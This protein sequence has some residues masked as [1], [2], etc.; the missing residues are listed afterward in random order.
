VSDSRADLGTLE[1]EEAKLVAERVVAEGALRAEQEEARRRRETLRQIF[2][3]EP[4]ELRVSGGHARVRV[5]EAG[6]DDERDGEREESFKARKGR[7]PLPV[8]RKCRIK[9]LRSEELGGPYVSITSRK[10]SNVRAVAAGTVA[11]ADELAPY[12]K[13]VVL[14]HGDGYFTVYGGLSRIG[15]GAGAAL[16]DGAVVGAV[17]AEAPMVFQI[18]AGARTLT[19]ATW[20]R[21]RKIEP[22]AEG[23]AP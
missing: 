22:A 18:R 11:F 3:A 12:G 16:R 23:A 19:P 17:E 9:S 7:L 8:Q 10:P 2:E 14:D 15:T 13:L 6:S 1:L 5:A 21:Q 4:G 20:F